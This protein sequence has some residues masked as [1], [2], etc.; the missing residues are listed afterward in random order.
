MVDM[1]S[2][3]TPEHEAFRHEVRRFIEAEIT[4]YHY[5]WE[6]RG[7]FP[8]ELWN[9]AGELG[10]LCPDVPEAYGGSGADWLYNVVVIEE[11]G[12]AG[13]SG[14]GS[15]F[16]VHS[17]IVAP[18]LLR[19]GNEALKKA[20]LPRMVAGEVISALGITEPS[21]GSDVQNIRTRAVRDGDDFV[22][23]GQKIFISNGSRCDFIVLACKTDPEAGAKGISLILVEK[24]R[25]GFTK[26]RQLDKIGVHASDTAEVFFQD[27]R[28][29]ASN[30]I[31]EENGGFKVM[32]G[33]LVQERL[34]QSIR[35][36]LVSEVA[37]D[38][39]VRYTRERPAFGAT[40]GAFQNTQFVL[41]DLDAR[42]AAA[43]AFT[44]QCIRLNAEGKLDAVT[45]A[46]LKVVTTELQGEVLDKCLQFFGGY[47]FMREYPIARAFV[48]ARV[49]RIAGGAVEVM[50]QIIAKD[51]MKRP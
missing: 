43:R 30:L 21:G 32:M 26:G 50:K 51:M 19:G 28:V 5:E 36:T 48:D 33:N 38:W 44:D 31:G 13:A 22:I 15:A 40:I 39:T 1:R 6:T 3:F 34:G 35:A 20:W 46:K 8:R 10:I 7:E 24:E 49:N 14:P 2:V 42:V 18:Y 23:N 45:T 16:L 17:E 4:P 27:V 25:E 41:A 11:F 9:R 37:I 29:P 12:R 47:G